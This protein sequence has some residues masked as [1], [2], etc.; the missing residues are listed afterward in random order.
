[1]SEQINTSTPMDV[2][3]ETE[4]IV[5]PTLTS[6]FNIVNAN[7]AAFKNH[8]STMQ[9]QLRQLERSVG[10]ELKAAKKVADKRT[11]KSS[12][13]KPSGFA[14]PSKV[15]EELC[16]FMACDAG[17]EIARTSVTQFI[18]KYIK[19]HNLQDTENRKIIRPD[20]ALKVLLKIAPDSDELT[21]FNLQKF[22]NPHFKAA[23]SA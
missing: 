18:I 3:E 2:Q 7:L 4:V 5:T 8:V 10:K 14:K 23:V 15:T 16:A 19:D 6:H 1:M 20:E 17:T 13:R 21:Y 12:L 22:M 9:H 11:H